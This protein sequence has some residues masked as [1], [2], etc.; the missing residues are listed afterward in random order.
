MILFLIF[1][2]GGSLKVPSFLCKKKRPL[3]GA[4]VVTTEGSKLEGG[5][6]QATKA[7]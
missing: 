6:D 5:F 7:V 2:G 3:R 1:S 4:F